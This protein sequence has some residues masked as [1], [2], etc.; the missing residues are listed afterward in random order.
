[1]ASKRIILLTQF[2]PTGSR[3]EK[4]RKRIKEDKKERILEREI[5]SLPYLYIF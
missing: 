4:E 2:D 1:M 3:E 5:E